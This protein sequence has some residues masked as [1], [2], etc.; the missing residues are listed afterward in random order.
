MKI[1]YRAILSVGTLLSSATMMSQTAT[2]TTYFPY[3]L[4]PDSISTLTGRATFMVEHFWDH[5]NFKSAFSSLEKLNGAFDTFAGL[6]PYAQAD[7]AHASIDNLIK[8]VGKSP[9]NLLSLAQ[10]AEGAFYNDTSKIICDEC[11]L[12]F[13]QAVASNGKLSA[14]EKARFAYQAGILAAS[15]VGM[16][17]PDFKYVTPD[18]TEKKFSDLPMGS[19]VLLFFNDPDCDDCEL[20]RV[21]LAADYSLNELIDRGQIIVVSILPSAPSDQWKEATTLYPAKWVVGAS[22]DIDGLY[23]MRQTP[24]IYYLNGKHEIL[25]K[26]FDIDNLLEAFRRV[27][28]K[29]KGG[30]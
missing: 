29:L 5:C 14:A 6:V 16:E 25:S 23:D 18:G 8:T 27:N 20:A 28:A 21:R 11:Y 1:I 3:P 30:D 2:P 9:K 12:P 13:A 17:A 22:A 10:M 4:V 15:Q 26:T 7:V 19:Y 24:S